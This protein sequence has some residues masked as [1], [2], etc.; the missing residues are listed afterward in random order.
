MLPGYLP[1]WVTVFGL[2]ASSEDSTMRLLG[3]PDAEPAL[4]TG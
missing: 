3:M 1:D 2:T 4:L